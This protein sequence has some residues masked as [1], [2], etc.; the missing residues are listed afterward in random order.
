MPGVFLSSGAPGGQPCITFPRLYAQPRCP[1][2][3]RCYDRNRYSAEGEAWRVRDSAQVTR[4]RLP[5]DSRGQLRCPMILFCRGMLGALI[6]PSGITAER[7]ARRRVDTPANCSLRHFRNPERRKAGSMPRVSH[8]VA[9][10]NGPSP[11][12]PQSHCS[13][14]L[15]KRLRGPLLAS[16]LFWKHLK[17]SSSTAIISRFTGAIA[18]PFRRESKY[19]PG[20]RTSGTKIVP[21]TPFS[22]SILFEMPHFRVCRLIWW[23]RNVVNECRARRN[24]TRGWSRH[25]AHRLYR[26]HKSTR[27][28]L[29]SSR[30][31]QIIK[32]G[33]LKSWLGA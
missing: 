30:T 22:R 21:S 10:A 12:S 8:T 20:V 6:R 24:A 25:R 14:S 15:N 27:G 13:A 19:C 9:N 4:Y 29:P 7:R 33:V 17:A 1:A 16:E 32:F 26:R 18:L 2:P 23:R 11:S 31:A 5:V 3:G 28:R